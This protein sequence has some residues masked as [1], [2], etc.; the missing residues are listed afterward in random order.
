MKT[1]EKIEWVRT[2]FH[3]STGMAIILI[4]GLTDISRK[5]SLVILG[6]VALFF[7]L[8]DIFRQFIPRVN[9]LA[10]K[11]FRSLMRPEEEKKLAATTYYV[12]GCWFAIFAFTRLVACLCLLFLVVG[13]TLTKIVREISGKERAHYITLKATLANFLVC[14]LMAYLILRIV[15]QPYPLFLSFLGALGASMAELVPRID[16]LT[17]PIFSGT[18]LTLGLYLFH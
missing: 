14:F 1:R 5:W 6:T 16:N 15:D 13:D 9:C 18:L 4:Y 11:I 12:I 10:K 8:G 7:L 2:L 17:I 3:I